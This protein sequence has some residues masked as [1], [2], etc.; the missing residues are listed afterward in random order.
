MKKTIFLAM[1]I[2]AL[3]AAGFA[4]ELKFD[5]YVNSGLGLLSTD[6]KNLESESLI[7]AFGVDGESDGY[8]FRL[9]GSWTNEAKTVGGKIRLQAQ[10]TVDPTKCLSLPFFYGWVKFLDI[11]TL[12]GG[13]VDDGT[14]TT[15]DWWINDDSGEGL[16]LLLKAAPVQGLDLGFGAYAAQQ[17]SGGNNNVL[18]G[19]TIDNGKV[20]NIAGVTPFVNKWYD[21]KYVLAGSYTRKDAFRVGVSF[22]TANKADQ[23][24]S[25]QAAEYKYS[26]QYESQELLGEIRLLA[27]DGLTAVAAGQISHLEKF[28]RD[29]TVTISETFGYKA[30]AL[31]FGLNAVEF[32]YN[33]EKKNS[34]NE[35][36]KQEYK[37]GFL[38]NLW[39]QYAFD[40]ISPR[41]DLAY[42]I[43]GRS[44]MVL[45]NASTSSVPWQYHRRG[46]AAIKTTAD[47]DPTE[48]SVFT[49]R[50]S[51]KFN[52]DSKT[53]VEIGDA[54]N[55]DSASKDNAY[56]GDKKNSR[57]TNAFYVDVKFSF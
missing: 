54:I 45:E 51:V 46:Y 2:I 7:K 37:P 23:N 38:F 31:S 25:L 11:F 55:F 36:V 16:G 33:G 34:Q 57:L 8:R 56:K 21:A 47:G 20:S 6:E 49:V 30:D 41:I 48:Y 53:F 12:T 24:N 10:R 1:L 39:G 27:I 50:P 13:L 19:T 5:G 4:Q 32:L 29:G 18:G 22:R 44:N 52:V 40:R 26:G 15:G 9:N 3:A 43:N 42:F 14:W 17:R 35:T 28:S